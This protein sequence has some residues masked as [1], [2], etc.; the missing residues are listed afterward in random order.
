VK[1]WTPWL[2][3]V[4]VPF[5]VVVLQLATYCDAPGYKARAYETEELLMD[6]EKKQLSGQLIFDDSV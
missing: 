2:D 5:I 3:C 4:F 1:Q 6:R